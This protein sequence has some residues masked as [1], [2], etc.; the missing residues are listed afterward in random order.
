MEKK[1]KALNEEIEE[2]KDEEKSL[3]LQLINYKEK[4]NECNYVR[5][6]RE[7]IKRYKNV[8]EKSNKAC[9]EYS[10]EILKIKNILGN[11]NE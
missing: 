2:I 3:I 6:L 7:E 11:N 4:E 10:L 1:V 5:Q 8:I 9:E